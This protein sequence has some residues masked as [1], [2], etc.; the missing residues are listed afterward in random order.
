MV[1]GIQDVSKIFEAVRNAVDHEFKYYGVFMDADKNKYCAWVGIDENRIFDLSNDVSMLFA[2]L[3]MNY[4]FLDC[5]QDEDVAGD[6]NANGWCIYKALERLLT[7]NELYE[8]LKT[9]IMLSKDKPLYDSDLVCEF[10]RHKH[11]KG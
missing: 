5:G 9:L 3:M 8:G 10:Y 4:T 6:F 7:S 11:L 2:Q 1:A